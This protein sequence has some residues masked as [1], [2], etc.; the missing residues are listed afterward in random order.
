MKEVSNRVNE[1]KRK[2]KTLKINAQPS[3]SAY[4]FV[5]N[6]P[7]EYDL[8]GISEHRSGFAHGFKIP[9]FGFDFRFTNIRDVLYAR[10]KHKDMLDLVKS[11]CEHEEIPSTFDGDAPE[12]AFA[13]NEASP[14]LLIGEKYAIPGPENKDIEGVLINAT[15]S[16]A[17]K[18]IFGVYRTKEGKHIIC[19]NLMTD[20]ELIAYRRQPDTFF[21]VHLKQG[22]KARD[23]LDLLDLFSVSSG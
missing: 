14:R 15:V 21:G 20:K 12:F 11:L 7:F 18:K 8:E 9:E 13:G 2:E 10:Q 4:V 22:R 5:T 17:E 23:A 1:L 16:E 19:T 3:P 6:Q